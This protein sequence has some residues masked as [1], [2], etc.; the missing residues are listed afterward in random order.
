[1]EEKLTDRT[2]PPGE[3]IEYASGLKV[4][5]L[6]RTS[7]GEP[8]QDPPTLS[9]LYLTLPT[10]S[11]PTLNLQLGDKFVQFRVTED[12]ILNLNQDIA[13]ALV[14]HKQRRLPNGQLNLSFTDDRH[15]EH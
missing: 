11:E 4:F 3:W 14:R 2:I 5:Y 15:T 6:H 1:M 10:P 12:Q 9:L 7:T 13:D 8:M